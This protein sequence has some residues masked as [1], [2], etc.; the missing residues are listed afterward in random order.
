MTALKEVLKDLNDI[1]IKASYPVAVSEIGI[2]NMELQVTDFNDRLSS[3]Y[4]PDIAREYSFG[5]RVE[6]CNCPIG[7]KGSSCEECVEGYYWDRTSSDPSQKCKK[8]KC[9]GHCD[10]CDENGYPL[11]E[12]REFGY[13]TEAVAG[14]EEQVVE[15]FYGYTN[16]SQDFVQKLGRLDYT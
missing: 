4:E 10:R 2:Q 11:V 13:G 15:M 7:H 9:H 6:V 1:K 3:P 8:C 14:A 5:S 16:Y 12:K